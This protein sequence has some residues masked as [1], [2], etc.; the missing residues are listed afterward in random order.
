MNG[1]EPE[2][3]VTWVLV[4]ELEGFSGTILH[5]GGKGSECLP[6]GRRRA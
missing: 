3:W 1:L 4:E 6:E 5:I 2:S